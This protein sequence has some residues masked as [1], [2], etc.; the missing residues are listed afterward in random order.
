MFLM[1]SLHRFLFRRAKK[2]KKQLLFVMRTY[3]QRNTHKIV[4]C[5]TCSCFTTTLNCMTMF[6]NDNNFCWNVKRTG[7][8]GNNQWHFDNDDYLD[9]CEMWMNVF[10][11]VLEAF[12]LCTPQNWNAVQVPCQKEVKNTT[13]FLLIIP[14]SIF[15]STT[16]S[17]SFF[18]AIC[19]NN[20]K[21]I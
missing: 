15:Y 3:T 17:N 14:F 7:I 16:N 1:F 4:E 11:Y 13:I 10:V 18:V 6:N 9:V 20:I 8:D 2:E 21:I 5:E 19:L 12:M